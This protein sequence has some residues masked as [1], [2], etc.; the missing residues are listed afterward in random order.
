MVE[1]KREK[2]KQQQQMTDTFLKERW[3]RWQQH[4]RAADAY[5]LLHTKKDWVVSLNIETTPLTCTL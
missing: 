4:C 1:E 5:E 2:T 3:G